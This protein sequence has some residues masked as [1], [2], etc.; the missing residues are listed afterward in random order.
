MS[1]YYQLRWVFDNHPDL[2]E[3]APGAS[4]TGGTISRLRR[5]V[6]AAVEHDEALGWALRPDA[7]NR[8]ALPFADL[9]ITRM[10][11]SGNPATAE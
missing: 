10:Q 4:G 8:T 11:A 2:F 7:E 9:L 1:L 6:G 3:P 5:R